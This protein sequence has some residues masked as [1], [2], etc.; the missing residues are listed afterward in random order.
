MDAVSMSKLRNSNLDGEPHEVGAAHDVEEGEAHAEEH[1]AAHHDVRDQHQVHHRDGS[2]GKPEVSDQL[3]RYDDVCLPL[4]I[5]HCVGDR[6]EEIWL[7]VIEWD[8]VHRVL[9]IPH[10]DVLDGWVVQCYMLE[11][12]SARLDSIFDCNFNSFP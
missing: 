1:E 11:S 12:C 3:L 2:E 6:V 5:H 8:A 7:G 4:N 9:D 10:G